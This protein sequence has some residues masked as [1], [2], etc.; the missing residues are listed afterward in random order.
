MATGAEFYL[1]ASGRSTRP[2]DYI[3]GEDV[4]TPRLPESHRNPIDVRPPR[5]RLSRSLRDPASSGRRTM[6]ACTSTRASPTMPSTWPS[7][8]ARTGPRGSAVQGV[9]AGNSRSDRA[10]V[11]SWVHRLP[12]ADRDVRAGPAGDAA[13]GVRAV[14]RFESCVPRG[15]PGV[16]GCGGQ[17]MASDL[18]CRRVPGP[19]GQG[20]ICCRYRRSRLLAGPA[21]AAAQG[22]GT[23][24]VTSVTATIY[25]RCDPS[26]PARLVLERGAVVTI[27]AVNEGWVTVQ[28][29]ERR[30]GLHAA[31]RPRADAGHRSRRRR[32]AHAGGGARSRRPGTADRRVRPRPS[33]PSSASTPPT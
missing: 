15:Q 18:S 33:A 6:A 14:R 21:P 5:L 31:Q 7:R 30:A 10:R 9:G 24:R 4:F 19:L 11:L 26:S 29:H 13:R 28:R 32:A 1:V 16:D 12:D 2:A 22:A 27:D 8:A 3:L 20:R 25:A 23:S 17:L